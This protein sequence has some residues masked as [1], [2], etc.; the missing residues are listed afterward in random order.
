MCTSLSRLVREDFKYGN[1][2][3]VQVSVQVL[4]RWHRSE[5]CLG[6]SYDG[7]VGRSILKPVHKIGQHLVSIYSVQHTSNSSS[8][9][10]IT[11]H[12]IVGSEKS[13]LVKCQRC[14]QSVCTVTS[15]YSGMY[16]LK[17]CRFTKWVKTIYHTI[18][19][20]ICSKTSEIIVFQCMPC[21]NENILYKIP[22]Q[23][24]KLV[25]AAFI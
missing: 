19:C 16:Y 17:V 10:E 4:S 15:P 5:Q 9:V 8:F 14:T 20:M 22:S 6:K 12:I 21:L 23:H 2:S 11:V 13:S 18:D 24:H 7:W 1:L 25:K 3:S